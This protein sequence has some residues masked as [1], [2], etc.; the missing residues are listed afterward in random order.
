VPG[1]IPH[2]DEEK[3]AMELWAAKHAQPGAHSPE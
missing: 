2:G 3:Q 1:M